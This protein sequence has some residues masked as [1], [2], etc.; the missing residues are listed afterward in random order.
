MNIICFFI[1]PKKFSFPLCKLNKRKE[2]KWKYNWG[3]SLNLG[4]CYFKCGC[5]CVFSIQ[6][7]CVMMMTLRSYVAVFYFSF[8]FLF[9]Y[10]HILLLLL[11]FIRIFP[12]NCWLYA[13][14]NSELVFYTFVCIKLYPLSK[15]VC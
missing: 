9:L 7:L 6:F 1:L 15:N 2:S 5:V 10:K 13:S 8:F 4:I 12:Y 11:I 14:L 3:R